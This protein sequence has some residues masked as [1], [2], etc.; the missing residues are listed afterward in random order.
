MRHWNCY[1]WRLYLLWVHTCPKYYFICV[2][3]WFSPVYSHLFFLAVLPLPLWFPPCFPIGFFSCVFRLRMLLGDM[4]CKPPSWREFFY[5]VEFEEE[6][7][8]E[9]NFRW[10]RYI[11]CGLF[12]C[13]YWWKIFSLHF[14]NYIPTLL[15]SLVWLCWFNPINTR[16]TQ[17]IYY[18][19]TCSYIWHCV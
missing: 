11:L 15:A 10:M 9:K 2:N 3:Q 6:H 19:S 5:I 12:I 8:L 13:A 14:V 4:A 16:K 18:E 7:M 1:C 17:H